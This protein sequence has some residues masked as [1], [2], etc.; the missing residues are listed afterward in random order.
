MDCHPC[1]MTLFNSSKS[2]ACFT[3]QTSSSLPITSLAMVEFNMSTNL[4]WW[5]EVSF[6]NYLHTM[7][8]SLKSKSKSKSKFRDMSSLSSSPVLNS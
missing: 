1:M 2:S 3:I 7:Q 5:V 6:T 8:V 4:A